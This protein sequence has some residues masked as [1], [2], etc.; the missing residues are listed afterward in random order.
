M[1]VLSFTALLGVTLSVVSARPNIHHSHS[2]RDLTPAGSFSGW[3]YAGCYTDTPASRGLSSAGY[4]D[5]AMT[6]AKC[7][8][9]CD[10]RGYGRAG[11]EFGKE[12]FCGYDVQ[13]P[14]T[15]SS[16]SNCNYPCPGDSSEPCGGYGYM[17]VF[18]NGVSGPTEAPGPAGWKSLGCYTDSVSSRTLA[19]NLS[20]SDGI[21]FV[22]SCTNLCQQQGF[23]YAGVE[24]GRECY[25][26]NQILAPGAP[27]SS[28]CNMA[29]TGNSKELCGGASRMNLYQATS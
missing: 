16:D 15:L 17:N 7:I 26:G 20:P 19:T 29:C 8:Q 6:D 3:S 25:C 11:V 23:Q 14:S 5:D 1:H 10:Q 22:E 2:Q 27:A 18:S 4:N 21:V 13:S 12:C 28:G 9:F 24:Y